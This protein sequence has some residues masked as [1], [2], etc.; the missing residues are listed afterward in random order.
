[1][2]DRLIAFATKWLPIFTLFSVISLSVADE[3]G[4]SIMFGDTPGSQTESSLSTT[5][6]GMDSVHKSGDRCTELANEI[7]RLKGKPQRRHAAK[8]QFERECIRAPQHLYLGQ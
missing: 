7:D 5:H 6:T 1:M 3:R 2:N 4:Q 8:L